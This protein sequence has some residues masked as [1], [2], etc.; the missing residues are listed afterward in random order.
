MHIL[1]QKYNLLYHQMIMPIVNQLTVW[2]KEFRFLTSEFNF[3]I[4]DILYK[5]RVY[6]QVDAQNIYVCGAKLGWIEQ[7][8]QK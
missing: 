1:K 7:I 4:Q 6:I 8:L 3:K 2:Q 5:K